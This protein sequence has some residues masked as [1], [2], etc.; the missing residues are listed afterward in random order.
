MIKTFQTLLLLLIT[1]YS[2]SQTKY[3]E[4]NKLAT[5]LIEKE[6]AEKKMPGI[7]ITI[8]KN[9]TIIFSKGFGYANIEN[10]SKI[11]PSQT[12][13]RIASITKTLTSVVI[14]KLSELDL[15]DTRKSIYYY[16]DSLP[17]KKYD[18]TINEIGGHLAGL[19]RVASEEKYTC[20]NSYSR[21][22]FY[23]VFNNDSLLFKPSTKHSYSNYG[24]KLLGILI[25]KITQKSI[26]ENHSEYIINKLNLKNTIPDT[27]VYD[28]NTSNFY[29]FKDNF[30]STAP[31][32]DCNFKH[33]QGCYLSTTED[34]NKIGNAYL[35]PN[36]ILNYRSISKLKK[37]QVF[38]NNI[39]CYGFGFSSCVDVRGNP[40][41]GHNGGYTGSSSILRIY[42]RQKFV[43][44]ILVNTS[45]DDIDDFATR[46]SNIYLN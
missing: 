40:F 17:K 12:K 5:L 45:V 24:F 26:T 39:I 3:D 8:S 34:L 21:K 25:E 28:E 19:R 41:Y 30:F 1:S 18:F 9:D 42:P 7:S 11:N 29:M 31:C 38:A 44:S 32:L 13:F 2:Y 20:D 36:R 6:A 14:M 37:P 10:K 46:I 23:R 16:L 15:L 43:I 27:G 35:Y 22:D 33:A 4:K